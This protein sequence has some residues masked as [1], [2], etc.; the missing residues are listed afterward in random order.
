MADIEKDVIKVRVENII[1][2]G[3]GVVNNDDIFD[4]DIKLPSQTTNQ[5]QNTS[6]FTGAISA[7]M[8]IGSL[9]QIVGAGGNQQLGSFISQ[10]AEI[11]FTGAAALSGSVPA[12]LSL[13]TKLLAI[14]LKKVNEHEAK[15][16]EQASQY[17]D[18]LLLKLQSGQV[19]IT[20]NTQ[21]SYDKYN[22]ITIKDRK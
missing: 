20:S 5:S 16:K 15:L 7:Q 10:G 12:M 13:N 18:L 6:M 17:N 2:G 14:L 22:K 4:Q 1:T 3:P 21:I 9:G 19:V 8:F 11:G